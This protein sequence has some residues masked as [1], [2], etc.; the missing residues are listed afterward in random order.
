MSAA[1]NLVIVGCGRMGKLLRETAEAKGH[2]VL[3]MVDKSNKD[4]LSKISS[5]VDAVID[6][7]HPDNL[8]WMLGY[9][10]EKNAALIC[11]TTGF[12]TSQRADIEALGKDVPVIY[13]ANY[14]YGIAVFAA[15]L[16]QIAPLLKDSFDMELIEAHHSQ[17]QDAP[18]GT[19]KLLLEKLDPAGSYARVYGREGMTGKRG[20]EIGVHAVRG[21]TVA[22]EH[23]VLFLGDH[24]RLEIKHTAESRQ[25]FVNGALRAAEVLC[26]K[27]KGV[28]TMR[29]IIAA[30][31]AE[32]AENEG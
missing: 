28:Y 27:P 7:S 3:A 5:P 20:R 24:E 15:L 13:S 23:T 14:S 21:G 19:A 31:T 29:D 12:D 8:A 6:F 10:R 22:G 17:K 25:I 2:T 4:A 18:S 26:T 16:E 11:G 30:G 9:V 1:R 32:R